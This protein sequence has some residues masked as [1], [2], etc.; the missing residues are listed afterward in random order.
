MM[1]VEYAG[2][3]MLTGSQIADAVLRYASALSDAHLS[4]SLDVPGRTADGVN[5]R[6]Q[7]LLGPASQIL[8]EPT[9]DP[10]EIVDAEFL[11]EI[12]R[13]TALLLEPPNVEPTD[14]LITEGLD[15]DFE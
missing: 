1:R 12:N 2:G 9:G 5:G 7:I 11:V 8:V 6:F 10:D 14:D 15:L 3:T 4:M 13:V